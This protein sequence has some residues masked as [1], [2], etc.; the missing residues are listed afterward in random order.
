MAKMPAASRATIRSCSWAAV[1]RPNRGAFG[2]QAQSTRPGRAKAQAVKPRA[3]TEKALPRARARPEA[4][5]AAFMPAA[6]IRREL[7]STSEKAKPSPIRV[8]SSMVIVT[9]SPEPS[10]L[11]HQR[12]TIIGTMAATTRPS[13]SFRPPSWSMEAPRKGAVA[14]TIQPEYWLH[15]E[16]IAWPLTGSP[17]MT[18]AM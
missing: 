1:S 3:R 13:Q 6:R 10:G 15:C 18:E 14:M 5:C 17:T 9:D 11:A 4:L 2:T 16:M 7:C 12:A 8:I